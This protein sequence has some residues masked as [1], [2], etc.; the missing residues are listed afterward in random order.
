MPIWL[1]IHQI[2]KY[3]YLKNIDISYYTVYSPLDLDL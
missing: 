2:S 3:E 1:W